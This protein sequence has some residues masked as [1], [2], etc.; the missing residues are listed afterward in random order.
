MFDP[1][2]TLTIIRERR[3]GPHKMERRVKRCCADNP[4]CPYKIVC[5]ADY[6]AVLDALDAPNECPPKPNINIPARRRIYHQL[7]ELGVGPVEARANL[8][9][10]RVRELAAGGANG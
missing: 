2:I 4:G 3:Y 9:L 7:R 1:E 8:S 6:D 10:S 5:N